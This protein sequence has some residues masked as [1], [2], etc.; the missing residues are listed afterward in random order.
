[1]RNENVALWKSGDGA[2]QGYLSCELPAAA[3]KAAKPARCTA[4]CD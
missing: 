4:T 3:V 1:V 2:F